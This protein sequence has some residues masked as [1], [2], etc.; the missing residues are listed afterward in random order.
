MSSP[1]GD[2]GMGTYRARSQAGVSAG[3]QSTPRG[4][5]TCGVLRITQSPGR[6]P[7]HCKARTCP[8]QEGA[9]GSA[10]ERI[11]P[12][13][14]PACVSALSWAR[15]HRCDCLGGRRRLE[16]LCRVSP[17]A[18]AKMRRSF[19]ARPPQKE[20]VIARPD[21]GADSGFRPSVPR[22]SVIPVGYGG[23]SCRACDWEADGAVGGRLQRPAAEGHRGRWR[24]VRARWPTR[25]PRARRRSDC[26][27]RKRCGVSP[28][29]A[30]FGGCRRNP[31]EAA[32]SPCRRPR[33]AGAERAL[34]R[35]RCPSAG[36]ASCH[37]R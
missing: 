31:R 16:W 3:T 28:I 30:G 18:R 19:R 11:Q 7:P 22:L 23:T 13:A 29:P 36:T 32:T 14:M 27:N 21:A 17:H 4:C 5:A 12:H 35:G 20:C 8:A 34:P 10:R 1:P 15:S 6:Q 24:R 26:R 25:S 37:R 33:T 9:V 2:D